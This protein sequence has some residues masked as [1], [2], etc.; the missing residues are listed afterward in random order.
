MDRIRMSCSDWTPLS[1]DNGTPFPHSI[2]G[3]CRFNHE[4]KWGESLAI[5][6]QVNAPPSQVFAKYT[7]KEDATRYTE[8]TRRV[9][10]I[11]EDFTTRLEFVPVPF[12]SPLQDREMLY[13]GVYKKLDD[14]SFIDVT[15]SVNDK[16]RPLSSGSKRMGASFAEWVRPLKGSDGKASEV[17]RCMRVQVRRRRAGRERA[18]SELFGAI[19]AERAA[20]I[21]LRA[22]QIAL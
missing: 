6:P 4:T 2:E 17:Y 10:V 16:R 18:Q 20:Q 14:G 15:Y 1:T 13:R 22:A 11:C 5:L 7:E 9:E 8:E 21:A 3:W 12:P 19:C